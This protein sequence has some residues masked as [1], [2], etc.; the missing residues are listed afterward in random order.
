MSVFQEPQG[1]RPEACP[2][3]IR[4][5]DFN[6]KAVHST[7]GAE[8]ATAAG[9]VL[10]PYAPVV[11]AIGQAHLNGG[12]RIAAARNGRTAP[13]NSRKGGI[14]A[15][16]KR[17]G[18]RPC[19]WCPGEERRVI[20]VTPQRRGRPDRRCDFYDTLCAVRPDIARSINCTNIPAGLCT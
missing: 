18:G 9:G 14:A 20:R 11:R 2:F 4:L 13:H 17:V 16:L 7:P 1:G 3:H 6:G 15:H 8:R 12:L 19:E 10:T 5:R